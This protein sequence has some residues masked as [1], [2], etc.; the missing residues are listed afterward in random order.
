MRGYA[1]VMSKVITSDSQLAELLSKTKRVAVVGISD[2]EERPS[3]GVSR[4][5]AK[6]S[7]FELYFV[8]PAFNTVLGNPCYASLSDLPVEIDMVDIFRKVSDIP[9]IIDDAIAIGVKS[10]W[11]QLGLVDEVSADRAVSAGLDVVMD[12][13]IKVEY[14][15]LKSVISP[16]E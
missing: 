5:L 10:I 3:N 13:C 15:R 12:L 8:N 6:N 11:I 14:D 2:K 7:H 16:Q 1:Y 9:A 4:W